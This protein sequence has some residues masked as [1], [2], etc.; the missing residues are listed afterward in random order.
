[1]PAT[2]GRASTAWFVTNDSWVPKFRYCSR[3]VGR[4]RYD[5]MSRYCAGLV[6][7]GCG[8]Q[9][10]LPGEHGKIESKLVTGSCVLRTM[11]AVGFACHFTLSSQM[12]SASDVA[13]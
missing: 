12:L 10:R 8:R 5:R 9:S 2:F 13:P 1:M 4:C 7:P 6:I 11:D 3:C